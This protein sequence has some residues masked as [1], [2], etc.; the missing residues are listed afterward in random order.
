MLILTL[1]FLL[2][3]LIGDFVL[4]PTSWIKNKQEKQQKSPYLYLHIV[5]HFLILMLLL[6][7]EAKYLLGVAI[8]AV[9]HFFIDLL[10]IKL[11][12]RL[13]DRILFFGDQI[14]HIMVIIAVTYCYSGET[15]DFAS[16]F[17]PHTLLFF[18]AILLCTSVSSILMRI[19][20][21]KWKPEE[22]DAISL[23]NAGAYIGMLERLFIFGFI[24]LNQWA[25]IGLLLTA[26]SVFRFGDLNKANDRKLTEYILI[27][28]LLSFGLAILTALGYQYFRELL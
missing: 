9:S 20:I 2:A 8:V 26:K 22:T 12:H 1:K 18:T 25:S 7:F 17:G 27:G 10:K 21:S 14:L 28:T 4:Q 19:I 3:H 6:K 23:K 13:N 16:L 15:L 11:K 24:V 5:L